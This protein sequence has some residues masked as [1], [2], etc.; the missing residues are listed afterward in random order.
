MK[1][2][3]VTQR[4]WGPGETQG[5]EAWTG[6]RWG[7]AAPSAW[8]PSHRPARVTMQPGC[9]PWDHQQGG[10]S[11]LAGPELPPLRTSPVSPRHGLPHTE[12]DREEAFHHIYRRDAGAFLPTRE[13]LITANY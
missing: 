5:T 13:R 12:T 2:A 3:V 9:L 11:R 4:E 6:G 10:C 8:G 7:W 1:S